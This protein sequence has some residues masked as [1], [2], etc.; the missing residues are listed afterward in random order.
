MEKIL[1]LAVL[2]AVS[3]LA[4]ACAVA[5]YDPY[6]DVPVGVAPPPERI[7]YPAYPPAPDYLWVSGYWNW[8]GGRYVWVPGRWESPRPG[9][10]WSPHRWQRDGDRWRQTGGRWEH[11]AGQR[12]MPVTRSAPPAPGYDRAQHHEHD[13]RRPAPPAPAFRQEHGDTSRA[14][15]SERRRP[16]RRDDRRGDRRPTDDRH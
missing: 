11:A 2:V 1:R 12:P 8:G 7:E 16:E 14:D 15:P 5:P 10:Y 3:M 4:S 13:T 9:Y 6:Y